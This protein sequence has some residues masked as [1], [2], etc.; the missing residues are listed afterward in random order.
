[1][2][3]ITLKKAMLFVVG[4]LMFG[5]VAWFAISADTADAKN[6]R[7]RMAI[8]YFH[9]IRFW[10]W[11]RSRIWN[12]LWDRDWWWRR[13]HFSF[14]VYII[15][16]NLQYNFY[17]CSQFSNK[18]SQLVKIPNKRPFVYKNF[19]IPSLTQ[20]NAVCKMK[21]IC[22]SLFFTEESRCQNLKVS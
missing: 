16:T 15:H 21:K 4:A 5:M 1:M 3:K 8:S 11:H 9:I 22:Y 13:R 17:Q 7:Q 18:N 19:T 6:R 10:H 14:K 12:G 2:K 20:K